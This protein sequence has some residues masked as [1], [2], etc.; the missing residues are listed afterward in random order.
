MEAI[1]KTHTRIYLLINV[2]YYD[3]QPARIGC[4]CNRNWMLMK[5]QLYKHPIPITPACIW[6]SRKKNTRSSGSP[7]C[8]YALC[9]PPAAAMKHRASVSKYF[10]PNSLPPLSFI[11]FLLYI[12]FK[13]PTICALPGPDRS[14]LRRCC[15]APSPRRFPP[16]IPATPASCP[17]WD[18]PS[19]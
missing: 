3:W 1:G 13:F 17:R 11:R 15:P 4:L 14:A 8:P 9:H 12:F 10:Y 7:A 19:A 2:L 16:Y 5:F 18:R 6:G